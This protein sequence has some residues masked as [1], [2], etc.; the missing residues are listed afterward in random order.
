MAQG[1]QGTEKLSQVK[2]YI[3]ITADGV[4]PDGEATATSVW[5]SALLSVFYETLGS[6]PVRTWEVIMRDLFRNLR[7]KELSRLLTTSS[8]K[9]DVG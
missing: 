2:L 6:A 4:A 8:W 1:L 7:G 3:I 9:P 5:A